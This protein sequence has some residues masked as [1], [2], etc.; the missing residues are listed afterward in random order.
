M[1][2][3]MYR[4]LTQLIYQGHVFPQGLPEAADA[5]LHPSDTDK[6]SPTYPFSI[7]VFNPRQ[8]G[9]ADLSD[10]S[11]KWRAICS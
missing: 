2:R 11:T 10:I 3:L 1:R 8:H 6:Q 9:P 4:S 7:W 5:H